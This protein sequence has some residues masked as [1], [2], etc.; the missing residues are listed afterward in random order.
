ME[1]LKKFIE[2]NNLSIRVMKNDTVESLRDIITEEMIREEAN[3]KRND[4]FEKEQK[5]GKYAEKEEKASLVNSTK[6]QENKEA[7]AAKQSIAEKLAK[8]KKK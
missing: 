2:K 8:F 4:D 7:N 1:E 3:E 5:I 6:N